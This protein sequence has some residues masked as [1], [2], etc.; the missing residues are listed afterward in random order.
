[1]KS[2]QD[3]TEFLVN[4]SKDRWGEYASCSRARLHT[5][6]H[7]HT[8][9]RTHART[10]HMHTHTCTHT[11]IHAQNMHTNTHSH[12]RIEINIMFLYCLCVDVC[13]GWDVFGA[14][15]RVLRSNA[16]PLC[17]MLALI[18]VSWFLKAAGGSVL[19]KLLI[20]LVCLFQSTKAKHQRKWTSA[21]TAG[22][23][24]SGLMAWRILPN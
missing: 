22:S 14:V 7:T 5:H 20:K 15:P 8:H 1:M 9:T 13:S 18:V 10:P 3:P 17:A 21:F 4:W 11:H 19:G 23:H 6:T 24:A 2:S 16:A 12:K